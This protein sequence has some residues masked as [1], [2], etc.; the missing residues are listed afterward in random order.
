[1]LSIVLVLVGFIT[2]F[3]TVQVAMNLPML[4]QEMV[5][6]AWL[7]VKG[8]NQSVVASL[9]AKTATDELLSAP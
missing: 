8:F 7:I 1:M 6:A 9:S 4:P 3:G 2:P 5:L